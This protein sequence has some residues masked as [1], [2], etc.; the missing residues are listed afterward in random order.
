MNRRIV[1]RLALVAAGLGGAAVPA[2]AAP[3]RLAFYYPWF[4]RTWGDAPGFDSHFTPE[5]RYHSANRA[6]IR[7]HLNAFRWAHIDGGI[8]SWRRPAEFPLED[9]ALTRILEETARFAP[10]IK[11]TIYYEPEGKT[12]PTPETIVA[13]LDGL[14]TRMDSSSWL[15]RDGR[16]VI[17]VWSDDGDRC[18]LVDRWKAVQAVLP[19]YVVLKV[20]DGHRNCAQ[21]PDAWHQ[22][23]PASR[24]SVAKGWSFAVSPGFWHH[25]KAAAELVRNRVEF[26]TAVRQMNASGLPYQLI[27]TFNEWGEG[28]AV[29]NAR[30]WRSTSG[31]GRYLDI[32][33]RNPPPR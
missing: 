29:E 23:G 21:Q 1:I 19:I 3:A 28:T 14:A 26:R 18:E 15:R 6:R 9:A 24:T 31:F 7:R 30:E 33:H 32:L 12:N 2:A 16:P 5:R 4:P 10:A 8:A 13:D 20:F 22:Y 17:F 11:W 25:R 27:T